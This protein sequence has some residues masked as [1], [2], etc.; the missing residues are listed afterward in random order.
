MVGRGHKRNEGEQR[1]TDESLSGIMAHLAV[2]KVGFCIFLSS[3][4]KLGREFWFT[5]F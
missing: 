2:I 4:V 1:T 5:V 3:P